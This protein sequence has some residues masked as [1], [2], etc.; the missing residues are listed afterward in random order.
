MAARRALHVRY[1]G[2]GCV[3]GRGAHHRLDR[4]LDLLQGLRQF[5]GI[6]VPGQPNRPFLALI[7]KLGYTITPDSFIGLN[8]LHGLVLIA[9]GLLFYAVLRRCL[10]GVASLPFVRHRPFF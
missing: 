7:Y 10:P 9:K 8:I 1:G 3:D 2:C 4:R 6:L 5:A